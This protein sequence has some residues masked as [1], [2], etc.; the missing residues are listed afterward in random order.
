VSK[1]LATVPLIASAIAV[2]LAIAALLHTADWHVNAA[3]GAAIFAGLVAV[4]IALWGW[5]E[6]KQERQRAD[7]AQAALVIAEPA[8]AE[9]P[10]A[11]GVLVQNFGALP[12]LNVSLVNL[13]IE[14]HPDADPGGS[15]PIAFLQPYRLDKRSIWLECTA[16]N[17]AAA[18]LLFDQAID[19]ATKLT[20]TLWFEDA[21]GNHWESVFESVAASRLR[22][23]LSEVGSPR[24]VRIRRR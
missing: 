18:A 20:A 23:G 5:L 12:V 9:H 10:Y 6:R 19:Q 1:L 8:Q 24:R 3:G 17:N 4:A 11:L 13:V 2:C 22:G 15:G 14:G 16:P 21:M 7:R